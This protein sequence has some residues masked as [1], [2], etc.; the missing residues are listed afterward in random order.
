[1]GGFGNSGFGS[2]GGGIGSGGMGGLSSGGG[3]GNT[4]MGGMGGAGGG[5]G[6][7]GGGNTGSAFGNNQ[8]A[9]QGGFVGRN[10]N[11]NQFIGLNT[12]TGGNPGQL[13]NGRQNSLGGLGNRNT[14]LNSQ[15]NLNSSNSGQNQGVPLRARQKVAFEYPKPQLAT[16]QSAVQ[17]RLD[18]FSTRNAALKSV[19]LAV[20]DTGAIVLHGDVASESTARLAEKLVRL[21]PGVKSVRSELTYPATPAE[22]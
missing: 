13:N 12:L 9:N 2:Q 14:N 5:R 6:G 17:V 4:G 20:D 19:T 15:Q 3:F 10:V 21:E 22:E 11:P 1:M 8:G 16:V 18:K 7:T